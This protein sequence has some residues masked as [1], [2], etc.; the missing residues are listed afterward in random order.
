M[1]LRVGT[2]SAATAGPAISSAATAA[3]LILADT[4]DSQHNNSDQDNQYNNRLY[5]HKENS[6]FQIQRCPKNQSP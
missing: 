4:A 6:F 3:G 5:I 2:S 1:L